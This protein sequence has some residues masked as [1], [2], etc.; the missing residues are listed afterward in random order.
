MLSLSPLELISI[1]I[2]RNK[3]IFIGQ[4]LKRHVK[5]L[6]VGSRIAHSERERETDRQKAGWIDRQMEESTDGWTDRQTDERME[7]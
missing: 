5:R 1:P 6:S 4:I 7:G 3:R 2:I